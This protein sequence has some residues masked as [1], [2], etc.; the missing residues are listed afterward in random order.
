[1][2]QVAYTTGYSP[3]RGK[4]GL[5]VQLIKEPNDYRTMNLRTILLLEPD[6]NMN[7]KVIGS[8]AMRMGERLAEHARDNYGGRKGLRAA[9]V[10]MNQL[11]TYNSIWARR[12][13]AVI[14]SNDAKGCYD[15]IA[16]TVVNLALQ[17]LG[18]SKPAFQLMLATIQE[19]EH[20]IRTVFGDSKEAYGNDSSQPP[21]QG[22]LQGSGS[23]PG[24]WSSIAAVVVKAMQDRGFG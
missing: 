19:M 22:I 20:H 14:M 4:K 17:R 16:H 11:L 15:R 2:P 24:G 12:G 13:R 23:G 9:E 7:N 10:S 1:M 6:H 5:D 21:P 18:V 3:R 8:D